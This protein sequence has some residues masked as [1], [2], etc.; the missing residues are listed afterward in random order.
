MPQDYEDS[1]ERSFTCPKVQADSKIDGVE[2][3]TK[4]KKLLLIGLLGF[5]STFIAGAAPIDCATL[6]TMAALQAA[7]NCTTQNVLFDQFTYNPGTTGITAANV[8]AALTSSGGGGLI[9]VGWSFGPNGGNSWLTAMS[10]GYSV[11]LCTA[12]DVGVVCNT[13]ATPSQSFTSAK[14]QEFALFGSP[15]PFMLNDFTGNNS[16]VLHLPTDNTSDA[17]NT[18]S[19]AFSSSNS[20]VSP[21]LSSTTFPSGGGGLVSIQDLIIETTIPEPSTMILFGGGLMVLGL[22]LKKLRNRK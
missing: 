19:G 21:V 8:N 20:S 16:G 9:Q 4:L 17:A 11:R 5:G 3:E 18:H 12:A 2:E 13:A 7:G 6:T 22:N 15:N 14:A 1:S 10:I